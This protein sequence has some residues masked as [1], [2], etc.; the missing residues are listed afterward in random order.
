MSVFL[1]YFFF[2][3]FFLSFFHFSCHPN[4]FSLF[5]LVAFRFF[6]SIDVVFFIL[7]TLTLNVIAIYLWPR[8]R[9]IWSSQLGPEITR[10]WLRE[11]SLLTLA[12]RLYYKY[13]LDSPQ[14]SVLC[15][16]VCKRAWLTKR[17]ISLSYVVTKKKKNENGEESNHRCRQTHTRVYVCLYVCVCAFCL[18]ILRHNIDTALKT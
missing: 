3:S 7:L 5:P 11:R 14:R 12:P 17:K 15:N 18:I 2:L 8:G 13:I 9:N 4:Y 16:G 6:I 10:N 1:F